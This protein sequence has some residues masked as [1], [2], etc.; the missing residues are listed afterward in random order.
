MIPTWLLTGWHYLSVLAAIVILV[1]LT[2]HLFQPPD[3]TDPEP[4]HH[5]DH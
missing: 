2:R 1:L 3:D 4:V 5:E